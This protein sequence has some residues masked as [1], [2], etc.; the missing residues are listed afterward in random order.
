M[1]HFPTL[2]ILTFIIYSCALLS[3][4]SCHQEDGV[5]SKENCPGAFSYPSDL[6]WDSATLSEVSG[7]L[8]SQIKKEAITFCKDVHSDQVITV[9]CVL[10]ILLKIVSLFIQLELDHREVINSIEL[11]SLW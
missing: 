5:C 4:L 7:W 3:T 6:E 2:R 8:K 1:L 11:N 9:Y 10:F